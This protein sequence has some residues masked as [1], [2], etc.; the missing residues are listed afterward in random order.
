MTATAPVRLRRDKAAACV[1]A[2]LYLLPAIAGAA[3]APD[4]SAAQIVR[5]VLG[6]AVVV[7]VLLLAAKVLPRLGAAGTA[8]T[9]SFR[10]VSSLPVGQRE[11]VIV[12]QLGER[13]VVL[14]VA[15]GRVDLL[16][17][18]EQ[19]LIVSPKGRPGAAESPL[20]SW[21]ALVLKGSRQ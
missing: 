18:L 5:L 9:D 21:L 12:L 6:L 8:A 13:Q 4:V 17:V 3:S 10:I 15:P 2:A 7:A 11:R 14:G 20:P 19:P 16:H 1:C